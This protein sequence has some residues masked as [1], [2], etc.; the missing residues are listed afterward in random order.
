MSD[1]GFLT[2]PERHLG[3]KFF[4]IW[5][6]GLV[7][8]AL[9][10]YLGLTTWYYVQIK[11]G[12]NIVLENPSNFTAYG[13][14]NTIYNFNREFLENGD[15]PIRGKKE[16]PEITIVQFVDY[17]C[18]NSRLVYK[19]VSKI[20]AQYADRVKV[21]IRQFPAIS[22]VGHE[23]SEDLA[24]I[25]SC[26]AEQ[27]RFWPVHEYIFG[28]YDSLEHPIG[29]KSLAKIISDNGLDI[30]KFEKC[31]SDEK[32]KTEIDKDFIDGVEA[33]VRGT[34]TFFVNGEKVEGA[35]RFDAWKK[36]LD[37]VNP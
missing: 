2:P 7:I 23:D 14:K 12:K 25:A 11:Q 32:T 37:G 5:L 1:H 19:D 13:Q 15:F 36:Y 29:V 8:L 24:K 18:P 3:K 4:Y 26:A 30:V 20:A 27:G 17:N 28:N 9:G 6:I 35:V 31:F 21:I 33:G 22:I 34:P 16:N 10:G